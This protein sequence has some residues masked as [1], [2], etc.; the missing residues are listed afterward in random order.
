MTGEE[1]AEAAQVMKDE[2]VLLN[3]FRT[4][5]DRFYRRM[6]GSLDELLASAAAAGDVEAKIL[7]ATGVLDDKGTKPNKAA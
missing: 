5:A 1:L 3:Q 6:D 4:I 7:L 2:A